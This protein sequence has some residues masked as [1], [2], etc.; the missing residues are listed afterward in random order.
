[1][2]GTV[3]GS[4]KN[5][6]HQSIT[7]FTFYINFFPPRQD[8]VRTVVNEVSEAFLSVGA[9]GFADGYIQVSISEKR[10]SH[11]VIPMC[12]LVNPWPASLS[13]NVPKTP[14]PSNKL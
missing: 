10:V 8:L 7:L 11:W 5:K 12:N 3:Y 13:L 1:M 2:V 14:T 9:W 6:L 4:L